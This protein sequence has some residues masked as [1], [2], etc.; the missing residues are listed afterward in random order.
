MY[1]SLPSVPSPFSIFFSSFSSGCAVLFAGMFPF[2]WRV[3]V[4]CPV[5]WRVPLYVGSDFCAFV[6][7]YASLVVE[8]VFLVRRTIG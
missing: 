8:A 5:P 7:F 2:L 1:Y 6:V 4:A 3:P